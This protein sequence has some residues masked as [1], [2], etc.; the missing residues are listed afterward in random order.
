[1]YFLGCL[2]ASVGGGCDSWSWDSEPESHIWCADY[3]KIKCL[4]APGSLSS[5]SICLQLK[6]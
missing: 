5:L 2:A 6:S 4:G 3:L 1:M